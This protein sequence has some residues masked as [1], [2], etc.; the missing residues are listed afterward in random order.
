MSEDQGK[1]HQVLHASL[2][3]NE[4]TFHTHRVGTIR[5]PPP[6]ID[7]AKALASG[8]AEF[9]EAAKILDHSGK[10]DQTVECTVLFHAIELGLKAFLLKR[11]VPEKDLRAHGHDLV[12]LFQEAKQRG[13]SLITQNAEDMIKWIN[14][15]HC[16]E[17]KIRY[18][19]GSERFLPLCNAVF[20]LAEEI[21]T[22]AN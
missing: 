3:K 22:A 1:G 8:A 19:F 2:F 12:K 15:W 13:L 6:G 21:I 20:P 5:T 10:P 18:E 7:N 16:N 9:L 4:Q 17:V 11:G 14:E